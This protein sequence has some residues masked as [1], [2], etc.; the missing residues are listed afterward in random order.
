MS[1]GSNELIRDLIK[2]FI[3]Q[4]PVFTEQLDGY[5][6]SG[7][8]YSLGKLAHKI[9]SSVAMMGINELTTDMKTLE[10]IA[11]DGKDKERYPL[12]ISNFKAISS[13]AIIELNTILIN[14][15]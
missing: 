11:E 5:Y 9:K 1:D 13:E 3:K 10:N 8:F 2:M 14:L 12:L 15:K 7:D 6:K 4:V